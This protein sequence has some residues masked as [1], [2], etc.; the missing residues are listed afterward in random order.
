MNSLMSLIFSV[1][2]WAMFVR[3]LNSQTNLN[4]WILKKK[5]RN[6]VP[7]V[8]SSF[9]SLFFY[10]STF[11]L[12]NALLS[13]FSPAFYELSFDATTDMVDEEL[14]INLI[15][16]LHDQDKDHYIAKILIKEM[17]KIIATR[18]R[19]YD[20]IK[21]KSI[22]NFLCNHCLAFIGWWYVLHERERGK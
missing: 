16:T 3:N 1:D 9:L 5:K 12:I 15:I 6:I 2:L 8:K 7:E 20:V 10:S 21:N 13:I 11:S 19:Y 22:C 18:K 14:T 4:E 17:N